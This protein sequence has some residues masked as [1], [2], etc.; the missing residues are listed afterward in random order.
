MTAFSDEQIAEIQRIADGAA[1]AAQSRFMHKEQ[2]SDEVPE[3]GEAL[4][5][6]EDRGKFVPSVPTTAG[7]EDHDHD[8]SPIQKLL[9]AN[10]HESPTT[11]VHHS[12]THVVS[13]HSD[14]DATGPELNTLTGGS[15]TTLHDHTVSPTSHAHITADHTVESHTDTTGTGTELDTL[16]DGSLTGLHR[17]SHNIDDSVHDTDATGAELDT[18]TGGFNADLLHSHTG[19]GGVTD[20]GALTGLVDNDHPQ[21]ARQA[22]REVIS[23][24]WAFTNQVKYNAGSAPSSPPEDVLAIRLIIDGSNLILRGYGPTGATCDICTVANVSVAHTN[25]LTLNWI[26]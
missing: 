18:L 14:T 7:V 25:S 17:H 20:H 3:D 11:D 19:T 9:Q 21:Y 8:G 6:D 13:F 1:Y 24:E 15:L 26:E 23:G 5:W 4:I 12:E 10:T 2:I 22:N 16:T